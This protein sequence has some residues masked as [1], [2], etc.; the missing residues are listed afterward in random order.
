MR[1]LLQATVAVVVT[2]LCAALLAAE[3]D[4]EAFAD[5]LAAVDPAPLGLAVGI[6][7]GLPFWRG[8]RLAALLPRPR[9]PGGGGLTRLSAEV[10]LWNFLLPFKLGEL[11]FPWLLHRRVGL[12]LHEAAALFVL[13]RLS[14][15]FAVA[16][17]LALGAS[18]LPPVVMRGLSA[19]ALGLGLAL[20]AAPV[21]M[22]AAAGRWRDRLGDGGGRLA[23]L[24][25]GASHARTGRARLLVVAATLG[26]WGSHVA[27]A[28]LALV[29][30]ATAASPGAT[31]AASAAGNLAFALPVSG[32]L[33]LGPQQVA[34][35]GALELTGVEWAR[36][37]AAAVAVHAVV[38]VTAVTA[39]LACWLKTSWPAKPS[40]KRV[41]R[42]AAR[43]PGPGTAASR[44]SRARD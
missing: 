9:R 33:G 14:D 4:L 29:A 12:S 19:P 38:A 34:F 32:V 6:G 13:V 8:A 17:L 2:A 37:V 42:P 25:E 7:L 3:L 23:L 31:V 43:S 40:A 21:V 28:A 1:R 39:G 36:A 11:S 20:L 27:I 15:L 26:L 10:L 18:T 35:A 44:P 16:G 5:V 22:I 24:A 41:R 30:T